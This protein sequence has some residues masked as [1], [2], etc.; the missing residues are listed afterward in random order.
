M[1]KTRFPTL[2]S[3]TKLCGA[4]LWV[5]NALWDGIWIQNA[6][7][8]SAIFICL[9]KGDA[10][11]ESRSL[12]ILYLPL[13]ALFWI[14]HRFSSA[15]VA[16]CTEAFRPL[17]SD[18]PVRFIVAPLL[19]TAACFAIF[20]PGDQ[21]LPWSR[22]ERFV[23]ASIIDYAF[24]TY[25]F[26][27]QHFGI[28]SLYRMRAQKTKCLCMRRLDRI[29]ALGVGGAL[30][31]A[32]EALSGAVAYQSFW[33]GRQ[34]TAI[35]LASRQTEIREA[36]IIILLVATALMLAVETVSQRP[37]LP[38]VLYVLGLAAMVGVALKPGSIFLFTAIWTSQHWIVATGLASLVSCA[39]PEPANGRIRRIFHAINTRPLAILSVLVMLS[40]LL[41]PVFEVEAN[42]G[43]GRYFGDRIFGA[44]AAG[45][46]TSS[47]IPAMLAIGFSTGFA[48][49]I[50][51]RN[52]YRMS[53]PG[54]RS[55][56]R[57]LLSG[58]ALCGPQNK[59]L[60]DMESGQSS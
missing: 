43:G 17:V 20:L 55:A 16:Y 56:A 9:S 24:A 27:A 22:E 2:L 5:S 8:L 48:H 57:H 49:Y 26:A 46:R 3:K 28:L 60:A 37:S 33:I 23:A 51:D 12:D 14:G 45:L 7:W 30:V 10:D 11:P 35:W 54:V 25:H 44:L 52:V 4:S 15:W 40:V 29:F 58:P 13:T 19:V 1:P 38:R 42:F 31:F 39:E 41:L 59:K 34:S 50:L 32:A 21:T 36:I 6:L 53:D 47:W 18:K